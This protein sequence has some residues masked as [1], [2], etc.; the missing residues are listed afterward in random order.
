MDK[1][2]L[3]SSEFYSCRYNNFSTMI[4]IPVVILLCGLIIFSFFGKREI[5][6]EGQGNLEPKQNV[7]I[8]QGSTNSTIKQNYLK[9][10]QLVKKGQT[11]LIYKNSRNKSQKESLN[12]Q[13]DNLNRQISCLETLKFGLQNNQ[14][15]FTN[16]DQFGYQDLLNSYL[17]Q[18]QIYL[19]ENQMLTNKLVVNRN[20]Q[21]EASQILDETINR[22][23]LNLK[24]Y[25]AVYNSINKNQSYDK[26]AKYYYIY[27]GYQA[28]LKGTSNQAEKDSIKNDTL[29]TAQQQ[30]DTLQDA[31]DSTKGQKVALQ[32]FDDLKTNIGTNNEKLSI[33]QAGQVQSAN[34]QLVKAKQSLLEIKTTL[35]QINTDSSEYI[36]KAPKSGVV[37]LNDDFK[38]AKYTGTGSTLAQIYP[39][40]KK[41]NSIQIRAYIPSQ[42][43]ASIKKKQQLRL[44]IIRNVPK[45]LILNGTINNISISPITLNHG[46][47]YIVTA[48]APITET[49]QT[50]IHYGMV[51]KV[52]VITGKTTF[53]NYYKNKLFNQDPNS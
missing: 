38:G 3:E 44:Q 6:I 28:N 29:A 18:R 8:I 30:I 49:N 43:I 20:K 21:K 12:N 26:D 53:F 41:Q 46:N 2:F 16:V 35:K 27:Q 5:S 33:L 11:L 19:I 15:S 13:I 34:Q 24:A 9:E 37:H 17:D 1:R 42:A 14:N 36:I 10:G 45:A 51:G 32:E 47:Y 52:S 39:N 50:L 22:T 23:E 40:L 31:V 48:N 25:Q 7:P 4:I